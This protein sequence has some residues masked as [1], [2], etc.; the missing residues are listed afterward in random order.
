MTTN[1]ENFRCRICGN[2]DGR[3]FELTERMFGFGG[4][5]VY[6]ECGNCNCIQ[7]IDV[8]VDLGRYYPSDKYYSLQGEHRAA[9][10]IDRS[11]LPGWLRRLKNQF[12][13]FHRPAILK[14]LVF[15][16]PPP[17][18]ANLS[19]I[20]KD[21]PNRSFDAKI[22]DIGSGSGS[23]LTTL[24]AIGFRRL[25]GVDPFL[26]STK[27]PAAGVT[28]H[29]SELSAFPLKDFDLIM[30]NHSLEHMP[31]QQ[32]ALTEARRRLAP[33][34][35]LRV[36]VPVADSDAWREYGK[37]WLDLDAPRHLYIHT[38]KSM[39]ILA[40]SVGLDLYETEPQSHMA[41]FWVSEAYKMGKTFYDPETGR[42]REFESVFPESRRRE[43]F[44]RALKANADD[45]SA[46]RM[47]RM[48]SRPA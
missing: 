8:P 24:S 27:S 1:V 4:S 19:S 28:L 22:L 7:I 9:S 34:G 17:D 38:R 18:L 43:F 2:A 13:L 48:K 25:H 15:F 12:H 10:D 39:N 29:K 36:E 23:L 31:D 35:V 44:D 26:A 14:P 11:R 16:K 32:A 5:F 21:L 30:M 3:T 37:Y 42:Y 40:A 33:G 20:V 47:F 46:R 45:Q 41:E 6:F